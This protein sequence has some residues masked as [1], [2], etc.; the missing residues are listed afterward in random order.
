MSIIVRF[1][2]NAYSALI[3][4]GFA[5][6]AVPSVLRN[7]SVLSRMV[8]ATAETGEITGPYS[9]EYSSYTTGI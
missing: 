6:T 2:Q 7:S 1:G 3:T 8:S 4:M 5:L 9:S